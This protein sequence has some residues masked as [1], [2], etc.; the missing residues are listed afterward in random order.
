M[1]AVLSEVETAATAAEHSF[2]PWSCTGRDPGSVTYPDQLDAKGGDWLPAVVPGTVAAALD[3]AGLWDFNQPTDL[4]AND[5]WFR[6]TFAIP[7]DFGK[8]CRLCFDGLATLSEI[9]LNGRLLLATDN[10]FRT[11]RADIAPY[12][13][14]ENELVLGFRSL[15]QELKRKRPRPRWKTNLVRNQQLRW[16]RTSLIGRIP[17]W[18]PCA[19]AVGPWRNVRLECAPVLVDELSLVPRL[20]GTTG[21]VSL[22]ARIL[23][24][25]EPLGAVLRVGDVE[26]AIELQPAADGWTLSGELHIANAP[27]WW[28]HTHG[29][30]ALL[31]CELAIKLAGETFCFTGSPIGFR[32]LEVR[33]DDGFA[34]HVNDQPIFCRGAC[35]TV[36]QLLS[37]A[38]DEATLRH[39]LQLAKDAGAN[40]LRVGATMNYES[41]TF[42]RLCD[43]LGLL[44]WQDFMFANMDYPVDDASFREN[45][46]LEAAEQL[47]RLSPHP[48]VV[49]CCGNSEVE[50]QAAMLGL[51]R[52]RWSNDWFGKQLPEL[53]TAYHPGAAYVPSTP[54]GGALP[55]H[56]HSGITHYYGLGAYLRSPAEVRRA[57]IKFTA[58]CLGFAN[59]P[60]PATVYAVTGGSHPVLH[61]PVWKRRVP[62]DGGAGWD[63]ED[64]RDHYLR[65]TYAVDPV[66]L[67]SFDMPRYL[68]LSR[69]VSGEM[70]ARAFSEWRGTHSKN[71]GALVWFYKDLWPGAGWGIVDSTG[72]PKAAYYFLKRS[73]RN[74]QLTLTDE[75]LNGLDLHLTSETSEPCCGSIEVVLLKEPNI[76][77]ARQS[78]TVRLEPRSQRRIAVDDLLGRFWDVA[79]AYRFGPPQ[80]DVVVATWFDEAG[81]VTGEAFHIARPLTAART[82]PKALSATAVRIDDYIYR[83]TLSSDRFLDTVRLEADGYLPDDNYFH[84]VP[85]RLKTVTFCGITRDRPAFRVVLQALN[86]DTELVISLPEGGL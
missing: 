63:F 54:S 84:L 39:D 72:L 45:I 20:M 16:F 80:H 1:Q 71:R 69:V 36:S 83:V 34:L 65:E 85:Q 51:P 70:M 47:T 78:A 31:D 53:C 49:V 11:Y 21:V 76:V 67:R 33:S 41:D 10:M 25:S 18:A 17:G 5:W 59:I 37:P 74:R 62:R 60:E 66:L 61:D 44:V 28:P 27:R 73:W 55:F 30:P 15:S 12:L 38:G 46:R 6:T 52:E 32:K 75:G 48:S 23:S 64:V 7:R 9:W 14:A 19:P 81:H 3:A 22:R 35:W 42:Y 13:Q 8:L 57:D 77:V 79:Y 82:I 4:D 86:L 40:M 50:Q 29:S 68:Q 43:E 24:V 26:S 2:G 56:T 58:E